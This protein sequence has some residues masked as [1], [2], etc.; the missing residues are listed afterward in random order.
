MKTKEFQLPFSKA[1]FPASYKQIK[2]IER[3]CDTGK[4]STSQLMKRL[5]SEDASE[6]ID[7]A[8]SGMKITIEG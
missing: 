2:Y 4:I 5:E 1:I 3:I 8:K 7:L 6:L